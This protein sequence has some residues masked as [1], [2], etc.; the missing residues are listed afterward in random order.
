MISDPED[1]KEN[2]TVIT[3]EFCNEDGEISHCY[4][5]YLPY[6]TCNDFN[7]LIDY[8]GLRAGT[9]N[10]INLNYCLNLS[11]VEQEDCT[12]SAYEIEATLI[13]DLTSKSIYTT[14][15]SE[16][17]ESLHCI[18]IPI[19]MDDFFS[20]EYQCIELL[21]EGNCPNITC[22][23]FQCNIF[24]TSAITAGNKGRE[25]VMLQSQVDKN[26]FE[27]NIIYSH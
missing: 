13:G 5:Y 23:E 6:R 20:G 21:V 4:E 8:M 27:S 25:E 18:D 16:D 22:S 15:I 2:G 3:F 9:G 11:E 26:K 19:H 1:Y 7:C 12:L 24:G 14:T 17:F 10:Y